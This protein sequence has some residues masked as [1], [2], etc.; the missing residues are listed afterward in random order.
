M[1]L[2]PIT[3]I[4]DSGLTTAADA[5]GMRSQISSALVPPAWA[6]IQLGA[7]TIPEFKLGRQRRYAGA[8]VEST[9][10]VTCG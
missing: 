3:M 4:D 10:F 1:P 2:M 8:E 5:H 9:Q 7:F 6:G